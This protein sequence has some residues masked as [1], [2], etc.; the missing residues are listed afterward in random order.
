MNKKLIIM[1]ISLTMIFATGIPAF[2]VGEELPSSVNGEDVVDEVI[3]DIIE[4]GDF[5]YTQEDQIE[6]AIEALDEADFPVENIEE[7]IDD[8]G[9]LIYEFDL[10]DDCVN[11][12]TVNEN[13]D[14]LLALSIEEGNLKN[15]LVILDDGTLYIDGIKCN[16]ENAVTE[17]IV[18]EK[19]SCK[20]TYKDNTV[21]LSGYSQ[22]TKK[23]PRKVSK[24]GS[25]FQVSKINN[26]KLVRAVKFFTTLALSKYLSGFAAIKA[27]LYIG[28]VEE[29]A[30]IL[31]GYDPTATAVS[32]KVIAWNS[33]KPIGI[34]KRTGY[35]YSRKGC[36]NK[37]L[38]YK[39]TKYAYRWV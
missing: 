18:F 32:Q 5:T 39:C 10:G 37:Y 15:E 9:E 4:E 26:L 7:A 25:S 29:F 31:K 38:V 14:D 16:Y 28:S 24:W 33:V 27:L 17:E 34:Q 23:C 20:D 21:I 22:W 11:Y 1:F 35:W 8:N 30:S 13:S 6:E 19:N 12:V 36:Q 3:E 2:A